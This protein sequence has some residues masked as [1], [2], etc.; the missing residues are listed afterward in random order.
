M[1]EGTVSAAGTWHAVVIG[2]DHYP[3]LTAR[4]NLHGAVNDAL[5]FRKLL[6]E[7]FGVPASNTR[8]FTATQPDPAEGHP[9]YPDVDL[10]RVPAPSASALR[11]ALEEVKAQV[12]PGD[13]LVFYYA[14]HGL[15]VSKDVDAGAWDFG[16]P[17][18]DFAR[19]GPL[20]MIMRWEL[21]GFFEALARDH[22][23]QVTAFFDCCH[24][25]GGIR[26]TR[27]ARGIES[28]V[29][30]ATWAALQDSRRAMEPATT[31][32]GADSGGWMQSRGDEGES[33]SHDWAVMEA[34]RADETAEE[35]AEEGADKKLFS[36]GE[37]TLALVPVLW[38]L[39]PS[40]AKA[41]RWS[42][43]LA[44]VSE[45]MLT[46]GQQ[47][48]FEGPGESLVFGGAFQ[49][50]D[51]GF[52][53]TITN[54]T[55]ARLRLDGGSMQGLD[56]GARV[57]V[58]PPDTRDF[59]AADA[60]LAAAVEVTIILAEP[61]QSWAD[62]PAGPPFKEGSRAR[63]IEGA[64]P[65]RV[66]LTGLPEGVVKALGSRDLT[67][68]ASGSER[69]DV[70][71]RAW[72][73]PIRAW[74]EPP[75]PDEPPLP[76]WV[77]KGG[78][79]IVPFSTTREHV[80]EDDV[81]AYLPRLDV[82]PSLLGKALARGLV[83]WARYVR[84]ARRKHD[85]P[86]LEQFLDASLCTSP[87]ET[88]PADEA[89]YTPR[90]PSEVNAAGEYEVTPDDNLWIRLRAKQGLSG[91]LFV[92]VLSCSEDG[93]IRLKWPLSD[94]TRLALAGESEAL[95]S[96]QVKYIGARSNT[97]ALFAPV[98]L[99]QRSSVYTF[100]VFA[101]AS[102]A[103]EAVNLH[104]LCLPDTVQDIIVNDLITADRGDSE[105]VK[106]LARPIWK[107]WD[108]RVRSRQRPA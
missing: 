68:V 52:T 17:A 46:V 55:P 85:D 82:D 27:S 97:A 98:R 74:R 93:D 92:G 64:P 2:I 61:A 54:D 66:L 53:V 20:S 16:L 90:S 25:G 100:K 38:Q 10:D 39:S 72:D 69:P 103:T 87:D 73:A 56:V 4:E 21:A 31:R 45:K 84:V 108:L 36:Q 11:Q 9:A 88:P 8:L 26:G 15:R 106:V 50:L 86:D 23:V 62:V 77:G 29:D 40:E 75:P 91:G 59:E 67:V 41:L 35:G 5:S 94:A 42:D 28:K 43:L 105:K 19:D 34:C 65:L 3:H 95:A 7:R 70:E 79:A 14:G 49:P 12:K 47:P 58:Y 30:A 71:V 57:R 37:F 33:R 78:W 48:T 80:T 44:K 101:Y 6:I 63:Q 22:G 96:G 83:H 1:S 102:A 60:S 13:H 99:N 76:G 107:T 32:G 81:I 89:S 24:S 51:P 104:S 18:S